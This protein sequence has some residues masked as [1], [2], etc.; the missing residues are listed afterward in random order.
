MPLTVVDTAPKIELNELNRKANG[1]TEMMQRTLAERVPEDLLN[2]FQIIASRVRDID[3]DRIPLLW[4]H[5]LAEDPE[6][7]HL[8]ESSSRKRF[9]HLIFVSN[10][11]F[12]T[13]HK[14][15]GVPYAGSIVLKN[16]IDPIPE[17]EKTKESDGPLRLIYHTTPHRGLDILYAVYEKLSEEYG[18]RLHLDVFSSFDIYGW[19]ERNEPYKPLFDALEAH[20]HVSYHGSVDNKIIR[21]KL[22]ESHIFAYPSTWQETSC[23]SAM[24]A[25]SAGCVVVCPSLAALPETTANFAMMYPFVEDKQIHAGLFYQTLKATIDGYWSEEMENKLRFQKIYADTFYGWN[26]RSHEWE[27]LLRSLVASRISNG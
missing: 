13:Y 22:K 2:Q 8:S 20:P 5:D 27:G 9:G 14:L 3:S 19:P 12:T 26:L 24:E 23:I 4:L 18:D 11:Q 21:E 25:M 1:G 7:R 16:A 6:A 15:L 17:H 10:W